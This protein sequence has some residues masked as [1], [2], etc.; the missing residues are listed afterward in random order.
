MAAYRETCGFL[1]AKYDL[2]FIYQFAD[3][4]EPDR[5]FMKLNAP[6]FCY[7]ID[8]VRCRNA[9]RHA[10]R[11][12]SAFNQ[13]ICQKSDQLIRRN[14]LAIAVDHSK[15]VRITVGREPEREF[16]VNDQLFELGD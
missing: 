16:F 7:A 3:E 12:S 15:P 9:S 14:E 6:V 4:F 13:I 1:A 11:P 10:L 8:Q 5:R 2:V